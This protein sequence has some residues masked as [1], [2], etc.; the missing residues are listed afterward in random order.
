MKKYQDY[1]IKRTKRNEE[2]VYFI[3]QNGY[4]EHK[5]TL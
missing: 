4:M 3:A 2:Y 1:E 5:P